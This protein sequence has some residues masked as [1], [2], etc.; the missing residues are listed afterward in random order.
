MMPRGSIRVLIRDDERREAV[1]R[2]SRLHEEL[3]GGDAGSLEIS[4]AEHSIVV[5]ATRQRTGRRREGGAAI[6]EALRDV[7]GAMIAG[8][9]AVVLVV[10]L[11]RRRVGG[12]SSLETRSR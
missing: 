7:A 5:R 10:G 1:S 9:S 11:I 3:V 6:E 12:S 8:I 2:T 4:G